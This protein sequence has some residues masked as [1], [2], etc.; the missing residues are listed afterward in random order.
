MYGVRFRPHTI[1][2]LEVVA[3]KYDDKAEGVVPGDYIPGTE[4][5]SER[6]P[7]RYE[8]N[9]QAKTVPVGEG[10]DYVYEYK[11]YLNQDCPEIRF[12]QKCRLYDADGNQLGEFTSKGFHRG[13]LDSKM[14]V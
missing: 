4:V 9:G 7:C 11:V 2:L 3:G 8:P 13:Q 5:W 1:S 6:F 10:R 14:W 12:G